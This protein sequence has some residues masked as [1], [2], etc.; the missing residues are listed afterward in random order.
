MLSLQYFS[1]QSANP[2][3]NLIHSEELFYQ[4]KEEIS[5]FPSSL[6]NQMAIKKIFKHKPRSPFIY[7]QFLTLSAICTMRYPLSKSSQRLYMV[8]ICNPK[9]LNEIGGNMFP[10]KTTPNIVRVRLQHK[11]QRKKKSLI[12]LQLQLVCT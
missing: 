1:C 3:S 2:A 10:S 12:L 11:K 4:S 8:T 7:T 9:C 5:A 6:I